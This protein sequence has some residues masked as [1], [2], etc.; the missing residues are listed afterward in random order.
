MF[1]LLEEAQSVAQEP[2]ASEADPE[3]VELLRRLESLRQTDAPVPQTT[4]PEEFAELTARLRRLGVS[5][6]VPDLPVTETNT[7]ETP[8]MPDAPTHDASVP[9]LEQRLTALRDGALPEIDETGA[10]FTDTEE[11]P[12]MPDVPT[13]VLDLPDVPT[14]DPAGMKDDRREAVALLK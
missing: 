6:A 13:S 7:E 5:E 3:T 1:E 9:S 10:T 2:V 11:V 4:P 8:S 14:H 12:E